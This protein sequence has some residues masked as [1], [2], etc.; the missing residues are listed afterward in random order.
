MEKVLQKACTCAAGGE[1]AAKGE[2]VGPTSC[3]KAAPRSRPFTVKG[4][5]DIRLK[6]ISVFLSTRPRQTAVRAS[7]FFKKKRNLRGFTGLRSLK[8]VDKSTLSLLS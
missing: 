7:F 2:R 3:I 1:G 6:D 4:L 8:N 5:S